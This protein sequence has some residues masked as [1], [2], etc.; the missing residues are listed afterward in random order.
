ME[1]ALTCG[2]CS[3]PH[4]E[5]LNI[6]RRRAPA[7]RSAVGVVEVTEGLKYDRQHSTHDRYLRHP[8]MMSSP[9][10]MPNY[11]ALSDPSPSTT[12]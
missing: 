3:S 7:G 12:G 9:K 2:L 5:V 11:T 8:D 10:W 1:R 4:A 6:A